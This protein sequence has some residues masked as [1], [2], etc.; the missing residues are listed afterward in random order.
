[1]RAANTGVSAVID[2]LG[3]VVNSLALGQ[4]GVLDAR[5]P[6]PIAAPF[7]ARVGDAPALALVVLGLLAALRCRFSTNKEKA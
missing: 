7:Y 5:L 6:R 3:R 2:P 4:E 1:V